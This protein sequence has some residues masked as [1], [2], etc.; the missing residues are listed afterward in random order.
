MSHTLA[1]GAP[2]ADSYRGLP[3]MRGRRSL[4]PNKAPTILAGLPWSGKTWFAQSIPGAYLLNLDRSSILGS[5]PRAVVWPED[6]GSQL[7]FD[8]VRPVHQALLDLAARNQPRPDVVVIDGIKALMH[9]IQEWIPAHAGDLRIANGPKKLWNELHGPAA[10]DSLYEMT[11]GFIV[12]LI[13]A[14]YGVFVVAH[15]ANQVIQLG[16]NESTIRPCFTFT[17]GF[18]RR[19]Y[20]LVE[21]VLIFE[22][23]WAVESVQKFRDVPTREGTK[24][25]PFTEKINVRQY[26]I[27][28]DNPK[29]EGIQ[30]TRVPLPSIILPK[31]DP[32][33]AYESAY[34]LAAA[35]TADTPPAAQE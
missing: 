11:V 8:A 32:W 6:P 7:S 2:I 21:N 10:Y 24:R 14:G 28:T 18:W 16:E 4:A 25:E 3:G 1:S 35:A 19:L 13:N 9:L 29:Y 31:D 23:T 22:P 5:S 27:V 34:T 20:F 15:L 17:D 33:S 30:K 26:Q 12:S